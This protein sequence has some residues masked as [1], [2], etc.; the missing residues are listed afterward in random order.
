MTKY[1]LVS[2]LLGMSQFLTH[3]VFIFSLTLVSCASNQ[4]FDPN[5]A[6]GLYKSAEEF[7]KAER[8]DEA[9][10]KYGEVRHR[11]PYSKISVDA[12]LK[13]A[14]LHYK[15]EAFAEAQQAYLNFKDFHP[16]HPSVDYVTFQLAMSYYSQLPETVDRDLSLA[17]KSITYFDEVL[18]SYPNSKHTKEARE[19]K[20]ETRKKLAA[21]E[22]YIGNFY[23][24]RQKFESALYRYEDLIE[25]YP[26][27]GLDE[28]ALFRASICAYKSGQIDKGSKHFQKLKERFPNSRFLSEVQS[29]VGSN[30]KR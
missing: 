4:T 1:R 28:K 18:S 5:S 8:Y 24:V 27:L 13:S 15:R 3:L 7:E 20:E 11:F 26:G 10:T 12:E 30:E 22:D 19:K 29:A 21:K 6:E 17:E 14:D 16:K 25:N 23:F 9:I 2:R